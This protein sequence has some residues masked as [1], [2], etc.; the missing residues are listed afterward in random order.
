M[1]QGFLRE[2][3]SPFGGSFPK[4]KRRKSVTFF[5]RFASGAGFRVSVRICLA[6]SRCVWEKDFTI[7]E[8]SSNRTSLQFT[9][10]SRRRGFKPRLPV[11]ST[12]DVCPG[13]C[14]F[15]GSIDSK[16]A[17]DILENLCLGEC[18]IVCA[19]DGE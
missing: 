2:G 1:S 5:L 19:D 14:E 3:I 13:G 12:F 10:K 15:V 9:A 11:V 4:S 6:L 18:L 8:P 17:R 16:G 7:S